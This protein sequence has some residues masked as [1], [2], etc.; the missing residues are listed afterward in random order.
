MKEYD[1]LTERSRVWIQSSNE[2]TKCSWLFLRNQST[3]QN[4][5]M[6]VV[7]SQQKSI[8]NIMK[9]REKPEREKT[10]EREK[11]HYGRVWL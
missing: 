6:N 10:T 4:R 2:S 1:I 11:F 5:E 9:I 3:H 8:A 7:K